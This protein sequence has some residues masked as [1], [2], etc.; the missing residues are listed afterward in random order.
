M[1]ASKGIEGT[2]MKLWATITAA[3]AVFA[4]GAAHAQLA[5]NS[6]API[7][8]TADEAEV[9]NSQC[10]AIWR[11]AAE[12]LQDRTRMRADTIRVYSA[13]KGSGCGSTERLEAEGNVYY[14]TTDR[15][16]RADNAVYASASDT[17]TLTGNVIIVQ[18]KNVAHGD[19]LVLN[20][21]TGAAD[22]TSAATGRNN[23]NRVRGVFFPSGAQ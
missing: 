2:A 1:R 4:A 5:Q 8:V 23:P 11:G 12:A 16:A 20:V 22:M 7:D 15:A 13:K 6:S 17:I 19:K 21:K 9:V 3:A 18:D 10:L 14:V